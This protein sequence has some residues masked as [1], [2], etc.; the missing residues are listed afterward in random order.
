MLLTTRYVDGLPLHRFLSVVS[1]HGI[2]IA[3]QTLARWI[4]QCSEYFQPLMRDRL[5]ESPVIH[6]DETYVQ[7]LRERVRDPASQSWMWVQPSGPAERK[8]VLYDYTY[9]KTRSRFTVASP[10]SSSTA[11]ALLSPT[12]TRHAAAAQ[13][14]GAANYR[15]SRHWLSRSRPSCRSAL[16]P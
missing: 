15:V 11:P 6:C 7:V 3:R 14:R 8:A 1:R 10:V 12:P 4:I 13:V 5:L 9:R 2:D 16:W